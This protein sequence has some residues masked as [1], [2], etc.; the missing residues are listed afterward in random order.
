MKIVAKEDQEAEAEVEV[1]TETE[2]EAEVQAEVDQDQKVNLLKVG[3][4]VEVMTRVEGREDE[5]MIHQMREEEEMTGIKV[6]NESI[7]L[8]DIGWTMVTLIL[9]PCLK[10]LMKQGNLSKN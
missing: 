5:D 2:T 6:V 8:Q 4:E 1:Q 3:P 10:I 9:H 7:L